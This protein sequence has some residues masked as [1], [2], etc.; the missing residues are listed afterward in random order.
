MDLDLGDT[1]RILRECELAGLSRAQAAYVMATA[2][3]E[4]AHTV[5]PVEEAFWLSDA[6]RQRN[7]RYYPWHGRGYVQLTWQRNYLKAGQALGI[8][9]IT[10]PDVALQTA[11]AAKVL[12]T[13]CKE[14]W[15]T[16]K[17]LADYINISKTDYIGARR[18]VNGTD[19]AREIAALAGQYFAALTDYDGVPDRDPPVA[20]LWQ[21]LL[22]AL[23]G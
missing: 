16:G 8:D 22:A 6:W 15:F 5:K 12:V 17:K 7:L 2:K 13:G 14:G 23:R 3:W 11:V 19:K 18:I 4:T 9:M 20:S 21:R 10:D 1:R